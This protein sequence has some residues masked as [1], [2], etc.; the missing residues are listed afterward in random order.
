MTTSEEKAGPSAGGPTRT[1]AAAGSGGEPPGPGEVGNAWGRVIAHVDMDAFYASIEIRDDPSLE[2]KPVVVGGEA[3]SRGVVSAASYAAREYGV[4]SAMPMAEALRKCPH[5]IRLPGDMRKYQSVSRQIM[6]VL[7][8][9]SPTVEPLSLDEAFLDLSGMSKA[10]G[11]PEEIAVRIQEEIWDVTH[12]TASVG[13]APVKFVAKIASDFVKPRGRTIVRP[14]EVEAFLHPLP[15]SR[16]WGV[17]PRTLAVLEGLG[18]ATVGDLTRWGEKRLAQKLGQH[19]EHLYRLAM[20]DDSRSVVSD[21]DA[22]SYSHEE[23]FALDQGDVERL[24]GVLLDQ[25][26]RVARRL[27]K[28]GVA[29][30]IVQ[31][32]L[33]FPP[34]VTLTRRVTIDEPTNDPDRIFEAVRT[35]F[36]AVWDGS[37]VRLLG[38]GVSGVRGEGEGSLDLFDREE[39]RVRR[40]RLADVVDQIESKFGRGKVTRAGTLEKRKVRS[41]GTMNDRPVD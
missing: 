29:G 33:R 35:L 36:R 13:V 37:P 19:G 30:R 38:V 15:L 10:L 9:Y 39:E 22:K 16:L 8:H 7:S 5:L 23:T 1:D 4:H 17:G 21:W 41:T 34:F 24:E 12:L 14:G 18:L 6:E 3:G 31:L 11:T 20:G 26:L 27:R 40:R 28:D 25:A 2:G 32:K